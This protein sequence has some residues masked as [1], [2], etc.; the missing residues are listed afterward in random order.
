[1]AE[2]M[3]A[4]VEFQTERNIAAG[5]SAKLDTA[6]AQLRQ[7]EATSQVCSHICLDAGRQWLGLYAC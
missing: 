7:L 3:Q 5:L 2:A 1:M 6:E 4:H